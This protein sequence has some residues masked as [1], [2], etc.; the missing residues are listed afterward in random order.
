MKSASWGHGRNKKVLPG[1]ACKPSD[2]GL[3]K[4][5]ER[6]ATSM[7]VTTDKPNRIANIILLY[8]SIVKIHLEC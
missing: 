5:K 8:K 3:K 4:V 1:Q 7:L 6:K 2:S